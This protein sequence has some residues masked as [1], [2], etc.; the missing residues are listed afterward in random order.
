MEDGCTGPLWACLVFLIFIAV[1]GI[2]SAFT[3]ALRNVQDTEIERK[4]KEGDGKSVRL[5]KMI[6][7][8]LYAVHS[9]QAACPTCFRSSFFS[10]SHSMS[11]TGIIT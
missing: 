2:L 5:M 3:T 1:N 10:D 6:D 7:E 9:A 4:A 8:P 11:Q